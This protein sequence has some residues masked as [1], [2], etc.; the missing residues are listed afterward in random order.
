MIC[1][2]LTENSGYASVVVPS[3]LNK[4]LFWSYILG[5]NVYGLK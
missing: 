4:T 2:R 3:P 1:S 5:L